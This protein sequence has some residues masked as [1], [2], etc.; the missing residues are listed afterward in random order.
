MEEAVPVGMAFF[1][2]CSTQL[3]GLPGWHLY[4]LIFE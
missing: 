1:G 2:L 4:F 3:N